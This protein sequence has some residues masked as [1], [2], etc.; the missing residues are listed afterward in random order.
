MKIFMAPRASQAPTDNGIGKVVHAME[1]YLTAMGVAFTDDPNSSDVTCYHAGTASPNDKN[2]GV[3]INHGL[4]W[5]DIS[6]HE[7]SRSNNVANQRII[8]AARRAKFI[9]VPSDWVAEPF[10]RDMRIN[11]EVIGHGIDVD[12]WGAGAPDAGYI[13]WNKNRPTDVCDPTPAWKLA[14]R[15]LKVVSTF[16]PNSKLIPSLR[17]TG[18]LPFESMKPIIEGASLYLATAPETFGIG[19]LEA[20]VCGIPVLGYNWCG[21]R[22]LVVHKETGYLVEPGNIDGLL[23]GAAWLKDHRAEI[24][25]NARAFALHFSWPE[26]IQKYYDL[27]ERAAQPEPQGVSIVI[28]NYNYAKYVGDAITSCLWQQRP[29]DEIIVVDDGS[30]DNSLQIIQPFADRGQ[31]KLISQ[32]NQ[33]VAAARNNGIRAA[34]FPLIVSLDADDMIGPEFIAALRPPLE[35]DRGLG[36]A[37]TGLRFL[38]ADGHDSGFNA[39]KPFN[40]DLQTRDSVPP[41]TCVPSGCMFRKSMWA[42]AGG[43]KQKY[44]PGEDT[45][46]WTN[47]LSLGFTA[48]MV[49]PET[50]FWYRGHDGSASR[51]K[52]YVAI[53]DNKPWIKDKVYPMGA[54]AFYVPEVRSYLTPLVSVIIPVGPG[55]EA[56]VEDA[57]QSIIG[58]NVREWEIVLINDTGSVE[59]LENLMFLFPFLKVFCTGGKK[60]AGFARNLGIEHARGK[61]VLFLDADDYL[62]SDAMD[63]ML[64]GHVQTG[65]YIYSDFY[66]LDDGAAV[67]KHSYPYDRDAFLR[68][69]VM[70]SVTALVPTQWAR[71]VGGFDPSLIGWE[72]YDFYMKL[73]I[74]G[75]CGSVVRQPLFYYRMNSGTRRLIS[76]KNEKKLNAAFRERFEGVE[77]A[78]CCGNGGNAILDAK[79]ALGLIP[80]ETVTTAELPNE[81]RL[82]YTGAFMGA[83]GY[84]VN[85]RT[86][87][88]AKDDIHRYINAPREDVDKLVATRQWRV[89][90]PPS[91]SGQIQAPEP[92]Q[93][94]APPQNNGQVVI[95]RG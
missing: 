66:L 61:F 86:Y 91:M 92:M 42:R 39:Y 47:G 54:P 40:W 69:Q 72:E 48:E 35:R 45:E 29:A 23:E 50:M 9:T 31:I 41:S 44:A 95:R 70:H 34:R 84:T 2:I 57:I 87:Y 30:T 27:Y 71:D 38:N 46:F 64:Q 5:A 18:Q 75:Y 89:I 28:S 62:R 80:R 55:H 60:G 4:Y 19:T 83:V 10:R 77:M 82:E 73:A 65:N 12:Q 56:L 8:D 76:Q 26:I 36:I 1:K 79:R 90:M 25:A 81:V 63:Q 78:S 6:H 85:G 51:T 20:M 37:Y 53:D 94:P 15:G 3:L 68:D 32:P 49:T 7:F 58:Q 43:Y 11:P 17:V 16:G 24:G 14:E 59:Y 93:Q 88:G 13:L 22:D 67:V 52:T 74:K 33:G 21:T